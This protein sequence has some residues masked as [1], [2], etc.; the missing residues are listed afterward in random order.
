MEIYFFILCN[1]VGYQSIITFISQI[2][3][4]YIDRNTQRQNEC[5][6]FQVN[7]QFAL[8]DK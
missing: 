4:Y 7:I 1:L 5:D 8:A 3:L 6:D 2:P